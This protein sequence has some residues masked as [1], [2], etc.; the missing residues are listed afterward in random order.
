LKCLYIYEVIT[1]ITYSLSRASPYNL[2][3]KELYCYY[4]NNHK[5]YVHVYYI[6]M[7][8]YYVQGDK[9][10]TRNS[11]SVNFRFRADE[12]WIYWLYNDVCVFFFFVLAPFKTAL[13]FFDGILLGGKVNLVDAGQHLKFPIFSKASGKTK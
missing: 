9:F 13:I 7:T 11:V 3:P 1:Y 4:S 2:K 12:R 6:Y 10:N 5:S 8:A